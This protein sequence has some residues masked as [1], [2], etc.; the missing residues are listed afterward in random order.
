MIP[1]TW[2]CAIGRHVPDPGT[3]QWGNSASGSGFDVTSC[4]ACGVQLT[5][6]PGSKWR[7]VRLDDR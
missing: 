6:R 3:V 5:R 7:A 2:F 4:K 1:D